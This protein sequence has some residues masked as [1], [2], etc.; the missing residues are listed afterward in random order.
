MEK[1]T[2]NNGRQKELVRLKLLTIYYS[3]IGLKKSFLQLKTDHAV[4]SQDHF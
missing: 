2:N 4:E 3:G 1:K